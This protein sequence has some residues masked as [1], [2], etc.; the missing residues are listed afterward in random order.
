M[1][2]AIG[3]ENVGNLVKIGKVGMILVLER[4]CV[5][6]YLLF[7]GGQKVTNFSVD[8]LWIS[9]ECYPECYPKI[10]SWNVLQVTDI[11]IEC[12]ECYLGLEKCYPAAAHCASPR[13]TDKKIKVP[14]RMY[15]SKIL[16]NKVTLLI[17]LTKQ[18]LSR[19]LSGNYGVTYG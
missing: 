2:I 13:Y 3:N 1:Q 11:V 4:F 12:V 9:S 16:T 14:F 17:N 8:N 19:K 15:F 18:I 7:L 5:S 6:K 10:V